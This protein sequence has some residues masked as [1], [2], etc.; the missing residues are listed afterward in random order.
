MWNRIVV[1]VL[2]LGLLAG[3]A[4]AGEKAAVKFDLPGY[5]A[6]PTLKNFKMMPYNEPR[7]PIDYVRPLH[8][9]PKGT[10]LLSLEKPVT[11][12]DDDP[13]VG[14]LEYV[15][16]G[17]KRGTDDTGVEFGPMRQW[18]QIDLE[19]AYT[20]HAILVWHIH[21]DKPIY[22]DVVAQVADDADFITNVRTVY[23]NDY[24]NSSGL[25]LGKDKEYFESHRGRLM[26]VKGL[27]ARY[28]RLYSKGSTTDDLNRYIEVEVWGK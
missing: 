11:A 14:E 10:R 22:H 20:I 16:N 17:D 28:V 9:A 2:A 13:I 8:L 12:S 1:A 24:D 27:K 19:Q 25:G 5:V 21:S 18:V 6:G 26:P 15:T 4:G 23:N 7:R 3:V